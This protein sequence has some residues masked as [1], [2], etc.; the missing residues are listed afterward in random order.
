MKRS[1]TSYLSV[2]VEVEIELLDCASYSLAA[3]E[4]VSISGRSVWEVQKNKK[5]ADNIFK[6]ANELKAMFQPE[7]H[8]SCKISGWFVANMGSSTPTTTGNVFDTLRLAEKGQGLSPL[9]IDTNVNSQNH[10]LVLFDLFVYLGTPPFQVRNP[11]PVK[12]TLIIDCFF[13]A[14]TVL[15]DAK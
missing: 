11:E 5:F 4:P 7:K 9:L 2:A 15:L 1:L 12:V 6:T 14:F 8:E 3:V 10:N 13:E